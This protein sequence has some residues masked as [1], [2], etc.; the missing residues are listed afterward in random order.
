MS[1]SIPAFNDGGHR[2]PKGLDVG[3]GNGEYQ[4]QHKMAGISPRNEDL[5]NS[6]ATVAEANADCTR[7]RSIINA[8]VEQCNV[9]L[10]TK[11]GHFHKIVDPSPVAINPLSERL[12]QIDVN[13]QTR[14]TVAITYQIVSPH[15]AA[16]GVHDV[17]QALT[18]SIQSTLRYVVVS[19]RIL[20]AAIE[21]SDEVTQSLREIIDHVMPG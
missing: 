15:I 8:N 18:E 9:G 16:F 12:I 5:Q 4:P 14:L 11:F 19:A 7:R 17:R 1:A 3:Q 13:I 6:Y 10:V 2:S 20:Q 21:D